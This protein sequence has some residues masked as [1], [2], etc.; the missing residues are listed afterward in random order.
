MNHHDQ[1]T[2]PTCS[3]QAWARHGCLSCMDS[4]STWPCNAASCARGRINGYRLKIGGRVVALPCA[5]Y[6]RD[7]SRQSCSKSQ[8]KHFALYLSRNGAFLGKCQQRPLNSHLW[9]AQPR[10]NQLSASSDQ[11]IGCLVR[12][13]HSTNHRVRTHT[14]ASYCIQTHILANHCIQTHTLASHCIQWPA[15]KLL[16][17][18]LGLHILY[19]SM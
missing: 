17:Q 1:E 18:F 19:P 8:W 7:P 16:S 13:H 9:V 3:T 10:T 4:A 14:L 6:P 11:P 5:P 12:S 2:R 15:L